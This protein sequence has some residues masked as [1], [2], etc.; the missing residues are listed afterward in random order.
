MIADSAPPCVDYCTADFSVPA[1]S[2]V[3][4]R[5]YSVTADFCFPLTA[6]SPASAPEAALEDKDL[7]ASML[8]SKR[9][10]TIPG[11]KR[12]LND[13]DEDPVSEEED[14]GSAGDDEM[15]VDGKSVGHSDGEDSEDHSDNVGIES[16]RVSSLSPVGEMPKRARRTQAW[17][18]R[19]RPYNGLRFFKPVPRDDTPGAIPAIDDSY[20]GWEAVDDGNWLGDEKPEGYP[21]SEEAEDPDETDENMAVLQAKVDEEDPEPD[22]VLIRPDEDT[23]QSEASLLLEVRL[24]VEEARVNPLDL[25]RDDPDPRPRGNKVYRDEKG[26]RWWKWAKD[27]LEPERPGEMMRRYL[28][29]Y[30]IWA[31]KNPLSL[32]VPDDSE[33]G[34]TNE[35][36]IKKRSQRPERRFGVLTH[37]GKYQRFGAMKFNRTNSWAS[38]SNHKR[39]EREMSLGLRAFNERG[40][41]WPFCC[42]HKIP[43]KADLLGTL[44]PFQINGPYP[45]GWERFLCTYFPYTLLAEI[46]AI[47][48]YTTESADRRALKVWQ[49][50]YDWYPWFLPR[51][52]SRPGYSFEK[53]LAEGK[54]HVPLTPEE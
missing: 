32:E 42:A 19:L 47:P 44:E 10:R 40:W 41:F 49:Y 38:S 27:W 48:R 23:W 2:E 30:N 21:D 9:Q 52:I 31:A 16:T 36:I 5:G 39:C 8:L 15:D 22:L 33:T 12:V 43:K 53:R 6:E 45:R 26:R 17:H 24:D 46:E 37:S 54:L 28:K 35:P 13:S 3:S 50:L 14:D 11:Q 20:A 1:D 25:Q 18:G 29:G 51:E 4:E 7:A 34:T